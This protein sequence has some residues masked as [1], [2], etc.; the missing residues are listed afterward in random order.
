MTDD[1]EKSEL[2]RQYD[3]LAKKFKEFYLS[4]KERG[5]ESMN[6]A[7]EKAHE[8]MAALGDISAERGQ[9]L[10]QYLNRDL[11]QTIAF[12]QQFG[13]EA[14]DRLNPSR[15]GDGAMA[16]IAGVLEATGNALRSLSDKAREV[17]TYKTGEITSVGTLTCRGCGQPLHLKKTGHVPPC[18]KCS[19]TVFTKGY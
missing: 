2:A 18:P 13:E 17:V 11:E 6:Q 1:H 15:L 19:G 4:G 3:L 10:K 5:R 12:A 7:L 14:K 16:S 8:Q 9:L